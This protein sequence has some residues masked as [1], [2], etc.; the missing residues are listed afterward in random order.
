MIASFVSVLQFNTMI[1][2]LSSLKLL[3]SMSCNTLSW[4]NNFFLLF[5]NISYYLISYL[6]IFILVIIIIKIGKL[7]NKLW[8]HV[9]FYLGPLRWIQWRKELDTISDVLYFALTTLGGFYSHFHWDFETDFSIN[10]IVR[11]FPL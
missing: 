9:Y 11:L 10:L 3:E 6:L 5:Y 4:C 2:K 8:N 1:M 7:Q